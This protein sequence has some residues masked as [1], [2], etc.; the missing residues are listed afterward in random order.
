MRR[1]FFEILKSFFASKEISAE[2]HRKNRET[3][4]KIFW[5][6]I[7][8]ALLE[9]AARIVFDLPFTQKFALY[10][11]YYLLAGI[12]GLILC[13]LPSGKYTPI[14]FCLAAFYLVF[15]YFVKVS[16]FSEV[17]LYFLGFV[18]AVELILNINP[19]IFTIVVIAAEALILFLFS[20]AIIS[21]DVIIEAVSV[22]NIILVNIIVIAISFWK[23]K[24]VLKKYNI[25][26]KIKSEKEKSDELLLSVLPERVIEQLKEKGSVEPE[27]FEN[28]SVFFCQITN[29]LEL[30][31]Y[32]GTEKFGIELNKVFSA[33]DDIVEKNSCMRIKTMGE[34][35]MGVCGLP[36]A[37]EK[38][39]EHS[40]EC[41][42]EFVEYIQKYNEDSPIKII[43]RAGVSS[44][45][46]IA[47][48]V[49]I[50]KYIYDIFGDT[51]NTAYRMKGL[52]SAM[53]IKVS[54][55]TYKYVKDKFEFLPQTP[56]E[57]KGKGQMETYN[58]DI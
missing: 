1:S 2:I 40:V 27:V 58:L 31:D 47:G 42:K 24:I 25:E 54:P 4:V 21:T 15:L 45:S 7:I 29:Y 20:M 23:R 5:F 10:Y 35:Y 8:F 14:I 3:V 38:H 18:I 17:I 13:K 53:Q 28:V 49:G 30:S 36:S 34:I 52:S 22:T 39:A 55:D 50:K 6:S 41:V 48:I 9:F 19:V 32:L 46:V 26:N 44:G 16:S 12:I 56:I 51:V 57:V 43:V 11:G 33:F 37:D